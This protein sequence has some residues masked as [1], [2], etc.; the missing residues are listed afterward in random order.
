M[1]LAVGL[2]MAVANH[3]TEIAMFVNTVN[4]AGCFFLPDLTYHSELRRGRKARQ[5]VRY[6]SIHAFVAFHFMTES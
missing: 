4:K 3:S 1:T 2:L 6:I 5:S